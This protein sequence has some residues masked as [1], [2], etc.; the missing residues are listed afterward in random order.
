MRGRAIDRLEGL[1]RSCN[2]LL[3]L[4]RG[5]K[6]HDIFVAIDKRGQRELLKALNS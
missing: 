5:I 1:G 2:K 4:T 6:G 3:L